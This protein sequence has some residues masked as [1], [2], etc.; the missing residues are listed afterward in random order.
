VYPYVEIDGKVHDGITKQFS[1]S[2]ITAEQS[3]A[4]SNPA[5][6]PSM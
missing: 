4:D 5:S 3:T 2:E 1:F 6:S